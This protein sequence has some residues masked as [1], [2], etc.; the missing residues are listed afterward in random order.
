MSGKAK[1]SKVL[2]LVTSIAH[3]SWA[4][5]N[6][7]GQNLQPPG[8]SPIFLFLQKKNC[9]KKKKTMSMLTMFEKKTQKKHVV[10]DRVCRRKKSQKKLEGA[11]L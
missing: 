9:K 8:H 10:C 11:S 4:L 2:Y 3:G 5:A 7:L 6:F 1:L